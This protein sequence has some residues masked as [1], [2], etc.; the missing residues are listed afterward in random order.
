MTIESIRDVAHL[1]KFWYSCENCIF[2][3]I[4][5]IW[6]VSGLGCCP[7]LL[8]CNAKIVSALVFVCFLNIDILQFWLILFM[9]REVSLMPHICLHCITDPQSLFFLFS[10]DICIFICQIWGPDAPHAGDDGIHC[11]HRPA[12]LPLCLACGLLLGRRLCFS[13]GKSMARWA[14]RALYCIT[15]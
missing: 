1:S 6:I 14:T 8:W 10:F 4:S 9:S 15:S 2:V 13:R 5:W 7:I 11:C 12:G 3:I